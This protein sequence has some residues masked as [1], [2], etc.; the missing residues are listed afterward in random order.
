M[1]TINLHEH[2]VNKDAE[3]TI[4]Q[5]EQLVHDVAME[6]SLSQQLL[7]L[8]TL[9]GALIEL[10]HSQGKLLNIQRDRIAKLEK[11]VWHSQ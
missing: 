5:L 9:V 6:T 7:T 11:V 10:V 2:R 3:A 1:Y 8:N 4:S